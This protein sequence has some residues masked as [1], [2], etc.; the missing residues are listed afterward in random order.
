M[1]K[2][3]TH[4]IC[5]CSQYRCFQRE[6]RLFRRYSV[7]YVFEHGCDLDVALFPGGITRKSAKRS[8]SDLF[9]P[10]CYFSVWNF[11]DLEILDLKRG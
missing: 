8:E 4:P 7:G 10:C 11:V 5:R 9:K 1:I 2:I 3:G 6:C